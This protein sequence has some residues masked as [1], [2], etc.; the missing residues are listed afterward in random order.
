MTGLPSG[1]PWNA[2]RNDLL[3]PGRR[4]AIVAI[5]Y[6]GATAPSVMPL[7]DGDILVCDASRVAI[8]QGLTSVASLRAYRRRGVAIFSVPGLHSKVV[9]FPTSAWV[10]SANASTNSEHNLIEASVRVAG[11]NARHVRQWVQTLATEDRE[12]S[13]RDLT[14][15]SRIHVARTRP[16]PAVAPALPTTLPDT[17]Q[18]LVFFETGEALTKR[19]KANVERDRGSAQTAARSAG[20]PS[21]L[22]FVYGAGRTTTKAGDWIVDIRSGHP[23]RPAYV[24]R[25]ALRNGDS[26]IWFSRVATPRRPNIT[27]LRALIDDLEPDFGEVRVRDRSVIR[28]VLARYR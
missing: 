13:S 21:Q 16:Q 17:V 7:A 12:L 22:D 25:V 24:V 20:F 8:R 26:I 27:Q 2:I 18:S 5:G 15:L 9:S 23:R 28:K 3:R 1:G 10:G 14:E 6:V 19:E 11:R 4:R